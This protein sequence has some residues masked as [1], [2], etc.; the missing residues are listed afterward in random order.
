VN[1]AQ[2]RAIA[3]ALDD[4]PADL[5]PELLAKAEAHLVAEAAHFDPKRLRVLGRKVLEVVAPDVH[6]DHERKRLAD[7]EARARR[8][9][10]LT[11][12]RRG[13][14]TTDLHV[15]VAD[16]VAGRLRTYLDAY[17]A[18]RRG[19]PA[20]E[21]EV[22]DPDT[23]RRLSAAQL[24]GHA[25]C[26]LLESIPAD[27]L[28]RHGGGATS[29]VVTIDHDTLRTQLGAA[30]LDTGERIT[31]GEA[32]RL[33]CHAAILPLV[34]DGKGQPLHLGRARRLFSAAQRTA[35]AVRD[36]ECRTHGCTI[37]ATWC[38]AH[39]RRPWSRGGR[40]DLDDGLLLCSW[41]HHRAH[42]PAYRTD[43]MPNGDV[44][45]RKRT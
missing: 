4:L 27:G 12:R 33:A 37:P 40:T 26:A 18:P 9:T 42:D 28:P 25:F 43:V 34:L 8:T 14:G 36:R 11:M 24:R 2:A 7:E 38:E 45:F 30:G 23:G 29:V 44:R 32:V 5:D 19:H 1:E 41:H 39:H 10:S 15:R 3:R 6:D 35:M 17:T 20:G 31:A 21:S 13:D 16:A 22:T